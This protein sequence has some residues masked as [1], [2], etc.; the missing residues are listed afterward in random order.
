L[1]SL[2]KEERK[3]HCQSAMTGGVSYG[4]LT[5]TCSGYYWMS[6]DV[7]ESAM[8]KVAIKKSLM[9]TLCTLQIF[10]VSFF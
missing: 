7:K 3:R 2:V 4:F 1:S 5:I 10:F 9:V 8:E 6:G